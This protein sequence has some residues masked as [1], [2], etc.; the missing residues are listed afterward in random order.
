[1]GNAVLGTWI[2]GWGIWAEVRYLEQRVTASSH[3]DQRG[4]Q[5]HSLAWGR[6]WGKTLRDATVEG[7]KIARGWVK[8]P[9]E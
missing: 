9:G 6:Y 3:N 4:G 7:C 2:K 8:R 5:D 1:M